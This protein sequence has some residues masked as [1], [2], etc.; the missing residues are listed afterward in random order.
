MSRSRCYPQWGRDGK[1]LFF[2]DLERRIVTVLVQMAGAVPDFGFPRILFSTRVTPEL[3]LNGNFY[4]VRAD[5]E[6]FLV[7]NVVDA[8]QSVPLTVVLDWMT[9]L[10]K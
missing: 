4:S 10:E 5:G 1:E 2:V 9:G 6:R 7:S 3:S 8:E